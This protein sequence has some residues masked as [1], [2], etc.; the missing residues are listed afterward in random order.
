[1]CVHVH[2][3]CGYMNRSLLF[4]MYM[5]M[6]THTLYMYTCTYMYMYSVYS[7]CVCVKVHTEIK[8]CL[9]NFTHLLSRN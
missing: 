2:C 9:S 6:Y 7:V 5:Y 1:M 3:I 8:Y 4:T